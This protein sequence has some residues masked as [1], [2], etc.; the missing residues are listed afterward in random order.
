MTAVFD[1]PRY[2][3]V[4]PLFAGMPAADVQRICADGVAVQRLDRGGMLLHAGEACDAVY[5][6]VTGHV[7]LYT[8]ASH[9]A[10]KVFELVGPGQSIGDTL[11]FTQQAHALS[12]QALTESLLLRLPAAALTAQ[13]RRD[14]AFALR[15]LAGASQRIQGLLRDVESY[16]LH[17]GARRV[18]G[19]LLE[20][21][22]GKAGSGAEPITVSLPVSKATIAARLSLTPEYFSRVLRELED[23]GLIEICRRD[24]RIMQ[25]RR[26][27]HYTL[28]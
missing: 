12:A 10:E 27:A 15:L 6:V 7:K 1:V 20:Q 5:Q 24:I 22:G 21:G 25:P 23:E 18:V 4:L 11:V 28:Q 13:V 14:P 8:I 2:L 19:Y 9:G 26:L 3:S 16:C 17:S